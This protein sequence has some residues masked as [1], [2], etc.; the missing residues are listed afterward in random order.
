V[1]KPAIELITVQIIYHVMCCIQYTARPKCFD[2]VCLTN[3]RV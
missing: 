3:W 1:T 2:T